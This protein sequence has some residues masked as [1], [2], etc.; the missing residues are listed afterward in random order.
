V[1]AILFRVTNCDTAIFGQKD[2]QQLLIIKQMN[3]DL[4]LGVE[5]VGMPII[6][7]ADGL[8][9]SSRNAYLSA[10]ER[11]QA[12]CLS[13]SLEW[14]KRRVADGETDIET[15]ANGIKQQIQA[16]P[17]ADID[18]V[19]LVDAENLSAVEILEAP[20]LCALA[21]NLGKTRLIDNTVLEP[22]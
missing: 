19:K 11:E 4:H 6:R 2:Y 18:Y 16:H 3:K 5:V 12:L 1:V 10:E 15:L 17:L 20:V 13:Q 8:A 21:V 22:K 9:M 7:E 14:A